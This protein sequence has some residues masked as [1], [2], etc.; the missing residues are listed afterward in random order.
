MNT[1]SNVTSTPDYNF[2]KQLNCSYKGLGI[3]LNLINFIKA[4]CKL[5][6]RKDVKDGLEIENSTAENFVWSLSGYVIT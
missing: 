5:Q 2:D 1:Q 4:E 3:A 6:V